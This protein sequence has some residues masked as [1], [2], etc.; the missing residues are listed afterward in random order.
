MSDDELFKRLEAEL[1][2]PPGTPVLYGGALVSCR[3]AWVVHEHIDDT[4]VVLA[5]VS[6]EWQRL[7]VYKSDLT[8][9]PDV[10]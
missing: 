3:G 10:A 5:S 8:V 1:E 2:L 4:R 9:V 7:N 6:N